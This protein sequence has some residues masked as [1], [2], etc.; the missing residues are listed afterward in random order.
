MGVNSKT[1]GTISPAI[2]SANFPTLV[3]PYFWT[4]H[5]A[6]GSILFWCRL[7]GVRRPLLLAASEESVSEESRGVDEEEVG[8]RAG[9]GAGARGGGGEDVV[10]LY[11]AGGVELADMVF[12]VYLLYIFLLVLVLVFVDR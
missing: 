7:G 10:L 8:V 4:T 11:S 3:P 6:A 12:L 9:A 5:V 1:H 2:F